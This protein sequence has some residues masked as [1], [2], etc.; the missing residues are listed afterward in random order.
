MSSL[1]YQALRIGPINVTHYG[2]YCHLIIFII[3][4]R[5]HERIKCLTG[6]ACVRNIALGVE[7]RDTNHGAALW[8]PPSIHPPSPPG[9]WFSKHPPAP[10]RAQTRNANRSQTAPAPRELTIW[11]R[12]QTRGESGTASKGRHSSDHPGS[13]LALPAAS[14]GPFHVS[15]TLSSGEIKV[16][17][18]LSLTC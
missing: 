16:G 14:R 3:H 18:I 11:P 9:D 2:P 15:T 17:L 13:P 5:I 4:Q 12:S 7:I 1:M 6:C 10:T 8:F